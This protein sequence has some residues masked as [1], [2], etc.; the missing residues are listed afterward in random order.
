MIDGVLTGDWMDQ[1]SH[2]TIMVDERGELERI[3]LNDRVRDSWRG[4][5]EG[6]DIAQTDKFYEALDAYEQIVQNE[7]NHMVTRL[8]QGEVI[9]TD[10][11][12][13]LHARR[14]FNG[15]RHFEGAYISWDI[16][17]ALWR[18]TPRSVVGEAR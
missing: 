3:H 14:S 16:M 15:S 18:R 17:K 6:M 2:P 9:V 11:W 13:V 8:E 7:Q 4:W 5:M 12:R 1:A 10:N